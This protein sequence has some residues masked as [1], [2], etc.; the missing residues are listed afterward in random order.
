MGTKRKRTAF[1]HAVE[2]QATMC[3]TEKVP[4]IEG[5]SGQL[6][7]FDF[8]GHVQNTNG[9]VNPWS[10]LPLIMDGGEVLSQPPSG[11]NVLANRF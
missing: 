5:I 8:D 6:E 10:S 11:T 3:Q 7:R 2:A 1:G 9:A 4:A